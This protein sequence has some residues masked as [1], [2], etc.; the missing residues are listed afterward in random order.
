MR[1]YTRMIS[2]HSNNNLEISTWSKWS[3]NECDL[4]CHSLRMD[5]RTDLRTDLRAGARA[6]EHIIVPY[7]TL[8]RELEREGEKK[9]VSVIMLLTLPTSPQGKS[10]LSHSKMQY[11][12]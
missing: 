10:V 2:K 3:I 7:G 4:R 9:R 11:K 6:G 12:V 8:Y 1:C 5:L